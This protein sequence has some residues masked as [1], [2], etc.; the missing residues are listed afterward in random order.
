MND[1][2]KRQIKATLSFSLKVLLGLIVVSP[3]FYALSVSFMSRADVLSSPPLLLPTE[4]TLRNFEKVL[5]SVPLGRYLVNSL[6]VSGI[7]IVA[8]VLFC[9]FAAYAFAFLKFKGK[10]LLF[11]LVLATMM[12]PGETTVISNYLTIQNLRLIDTYA[13]LVAPGLVSGMGIFLL[14]QFYLTVPME[15]KDA[16]TVD[17]CGHFSF[18]IRILMP[19]SLTSITS[20]SIYLFVRTYNAFFWPLLVT[21]SDDMRTIQIGISYLMNSEAVDY[22]V[23]IAG[24]V[25]ALIIPILVF[26]LGLRYLISGMTAG[27]VKG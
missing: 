3:L 6:I 18:F 22:G 17:G 8:Q 1:R 24:A 10:N 21:N 19:I 23:V 2:Q 7:E 9:S 25:L 12:I 26:I 15:I 13:G 14:R 11:T 16:A 4:P 5:E 20:L 27:A